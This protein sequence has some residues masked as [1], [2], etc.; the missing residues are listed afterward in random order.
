[1]VF[2]K[3]KKETLRTKVLRK[4]ILRTKVLRMTGMMGQKRR[5]FG[6][7]ASGW[8]KRGDPSAL[9]PQD[10]KNLPTVSF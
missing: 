5:S 2:I 9:Q 3:F 1:V 8:V 7:T 4:E 6:F 10:D